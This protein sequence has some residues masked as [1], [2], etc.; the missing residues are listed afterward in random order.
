[1][2]RG[3]EFPAELLPVLQ[4][5]R[6]SFISVKWPGVMLWFHYGTLIAFEAKGRQYVRENEWGNTTGRCLNWIDGG[7]PQAKK[8]RLD[9]KAF[10]AA[11]R[12]EMKSVM[13]RPTICMG[14]SREV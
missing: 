2:G 6:G 13:A 5:R 11:W 14:F 10:A 4:V 9:R 12:K 1:M 8:Q 7:S 3:Q